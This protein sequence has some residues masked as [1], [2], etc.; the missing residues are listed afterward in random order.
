[1]TN[2]ADLKFFDNTRISSFKVCPRRY[3]YEHV[4]HWRPDS[5]SVA[6]TFGSAWHAAQDVIWGAQTGGSLHLMA[7]KRDSNKAL[8][9]EAYAAFI[10]TWLEDKL[11]HPDEMS[12]DEL[13]DFAPR[14]PQ[15]AKEML[16]AYIDARSHLFQDP[17]FKVVDVE[18][19]FAVPLDPDDASLWYVGRL[20]KVFQY[21]GSFYVG[22]H[23]TTTAYKKGSYFRSD[24]LDSFSPSS[25]IDGYLFAL[26]MMFGDKASAV[27]VDA[28]LVHKIEH[29]GFKFIPIERQHQMIDAFLWTTR[30][31][32]DEIEG[33]KL[34]LA[35]R[36]ADDAPYLAAFPQN[37]SSCG[38]YGG[39]PFRSI[40]QTIANP[41]KET[42]PPLGFKTE[43]WDPLQKIDL[44]KIGFEL[45]ATAPAAAKEPA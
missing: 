8:V 1:M 6:L 35:E 23:K 17:S 18:R 9:D 29:D 26:R 44:S 7:V 41:A 33:N 31:W 21:R 22:E 45:P 20:D 39:C 13:A 11:P 15:I 28:A 10:K 37:T 42:Q 38:Q 24:F 16:Y 5:K 19:P 36:E 4:R 14:T 34:A 43:I 32:I 40:C 30:H 25:Q 3:Y 27:W 12:P 2:T